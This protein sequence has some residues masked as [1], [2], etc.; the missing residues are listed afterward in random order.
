M[1]RKHHLVTYC[2]ESV[3]FNARF[4]AIKI[5]AQ[6]GKAKWVEL[7]RTLKHLPG[8]F[9]IMPIIHQFSLQPRCICNLGT[10]EWFSYVLSVLFLIF[11][12]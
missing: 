2:F 11:D 6:T 10:H 9:G 1:V 3:R 7:N 4:A 8:N 12:K 5:E